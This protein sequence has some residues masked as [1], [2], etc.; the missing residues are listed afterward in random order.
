VLAREFTTLFEGGAFFEGPRWREGRWW[1]S[2]FY[3]HVVM[4]VAPD[5]TPTTVMSV[6][7]Q[8]SGLGWMPDGSL[9]VVSMRDHR[10]LRRS[11]TGEVSVHADLTAHCAG[12]LND[13]VVDRRGRAYVGEF[14]FDLM[15]FADPAP[16]KLMR[17]D[18]D[19]SVTVL[20]DDMRFPN[21]MVITPDDGTLIVGETAG[22]RFTAFTL[23]DDGSLS[24]RRVW[25]QVAFT[26]E[27]GPFEQTFPQLKFAPD[28]CTLDAEG[29]IW[30]ADAIGALRPRRAGWRDPRGDT[31]ARRPGHLRLRTRR[32]GRVHAAAL[33]RAGLPGGQPRAHARGGAAH[34]RHRR[35]ARRAALR[36][37]RARA[38][39]S[40]ALHWPATSRRL[41]SKTTELLDCLD[42]RVVDFKLRDKEIVLVAR[43]SPARLGGRFSKTG[44]AARLLEDRM[45]E[46]R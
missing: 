42:G 18:P 16:G 14:G 15:G 19:G 9:L 11:S 40:Q 34:D 45:I 33:R 28:G 10:V 39:R 29:C 24:D 1:V 41:M 37:P 21:G 8:P 17:V 2:D 4:T 32:R 6:E 44:M 23:E 3:G 20:D 35:T 5:G 36:G 38:P 22:A 12:H 25:A 26:P 31:D 46:H 30:A 13:M 43:R 7:Q 27:L